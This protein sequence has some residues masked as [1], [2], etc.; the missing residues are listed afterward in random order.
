MRLARSAVTL[1]LALA[2]LPAAA[3]SAPDNVVKAGVEAWTRGDFAAAIRSWEGPAANGDAD[4]EFNLA[5][6]YKLGKGVPADLRRAEALYLAA[7]QQGHLQAADNYGL[8]LF[9]SGRREAAMAWIVPSAERGEPRAQYV[10][11]IAHFNGD[12]VPSDPVRAY[13]LMTR[14]AATGL[15]QARA[16][17]ATMDQALTLDERQQGAALAAELETRAN[18]LRST[19]FASADLVG[20]SDKPKRVVGTGGM[21]AGVK[22]SPPA[23]VVLQTAPVTAGADY[24]LPVT[25]GPPIVA[26]RPAPPAPVVVRSGAWKIQLGAFGV[27]GNAQALWARLKGGAVLAGR[28]PSYVPAGRL[29]R[30]LAGPF[31]TRGEAQ[32]ACEALAGQACIA[33]Q[34]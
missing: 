34:K 1:A 27:A 30:L 9:Q 17:L 6:A 19:Q 2:A 3:K 15:D 20:T 23:V 21:K 25:L 16:T 4:A 29:T 18:A 13:A 11:G 12:L 26:V 31:A 22:T 33:V 7:A 24:A 14:A 28:E 10:L 32:A 5:Q 8:L